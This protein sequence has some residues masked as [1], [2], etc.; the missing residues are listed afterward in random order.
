M[1]TLQID[2]YN[3]TISRVRKSDNSGKLVYLVDLGDDTYAEH[4]VVWLDAKMA[5]A[6]YNNPAGDY[7]RW[8]KNMALDRLKPPE[9]RDKKLPSRQ[10]I[11]SVLISSRR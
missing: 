11:K 8:A 10:P 4:T 7:P 2:G 9:A 5:D 3:I 1:K 6:A